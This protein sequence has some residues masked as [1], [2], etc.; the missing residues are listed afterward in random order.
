LLPDEKLELEHRHAGGLGLMFAGEPAVQVAMDGWFRR[1]GPDNKPAALLSGAFN[2]LHT[3][4]WE[5]AACAERLLGIPVFF[6]LSIENVDKPVLTP[7]EVRRRL[8]QFHW[9]A[10]VWLT[11][12]P[13]FL[14]KA[15][16]FP[17]AVFVVGADT[18]E[19]IIAPRYYGEGED[20]MMRALAGIRDLGCRFLVAGRLNR[21]ADFLSLDD[22]S[23]PADFRA[24]FSSISPAEFRLDLCSTDLRTE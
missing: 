13:T 10:P 15:R 11:R 1:I 23:V 19:R 3:G 24:L 18:A 14:D 9:R 22:L 4:H 16:L 5:L 2:P 12:A 7:R 6:E 17:G 21:A 20:G 8:A